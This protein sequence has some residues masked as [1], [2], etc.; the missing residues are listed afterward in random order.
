MLAGMVAIFTAGGKARVIDCTID[1][2]CRTSIYEF[3]GAAVEPG[4]AI[5]P[6]TI[7][8]KNHFRAS[9]VGDPTDFL[10]KSS[11][12]PQYAKNC[13]LRH[14][15]DEMLEGLRKTSSGRRGRLFV[16][17]EEYRK[18]EPVRMRDGECLAIDQG[19]VKGGTSGSES[20][21][22][23]RSM[24]GA[25]PEE[26]A[27]ISSENVVLAAIK[28]EQNVRYGMKA[29]MESFN[30]VERDGNIVHIQ[31]GYA[32][33]AFDVLRSERELSDQALQEKAHKLSCN[34]LL[35]EKLVEQPPVSELITALRLEDTREKSHLCLWYLRL[36][37]ASCEAGPL[38]GSP[39]FGNPEGTRIGQ[40][41][42]RKQLEHRNDVAHGRVNEIDYAVFERLQRDVLDLMRN[43]ILRRS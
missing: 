1:G 10:K 35:L 16:I 4:A 21:L 18:I 13:A 33:I 39:Q 17:I 2:Y 43:D 20:I 7:C 26:G 38:I 9:I 40:D 32:D 29:L 22:A 31:E 36:W 3:C 5:E 14:D 42:R 25:W 23:L 24:D 34:I 41:E 27:D 30:F 37:E 11:F 6:K 19:L 28:I 8:Q 15:L 12:S